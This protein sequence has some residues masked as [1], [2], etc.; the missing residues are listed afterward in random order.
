MDAIESVHETQSLNRNGTMLKDGNERNNSEHTKDGSTDCLGRPAARAKTGGWTSGMLLLVN[1]GLGA[2]AFVGVEVNLVLFSTRVLKQTNAEAANTFSRWMGTGMVLLTVSTHFS[3]LTPHGCGKVDFVCD[4]QSSLDMA[5]FY[6][7]IYLIA[8]GNGGYEPSLA[9]LGADQFDEEDETE[10]R[11]K[12]SFFSYFY[13]ALNLGSMFSETALAYFQN[14]GKWVMGFWISTGCGLIGLTVFLSGSL[15]Y[16]HFKPCGNPISRFSQVMCACFRKLKLEVPPDGEGLYE[17]QGNIGAASGARKINHTN[18]FRFLDRAAILSPKDTVVMTNSTNIFDPWSLCTVTQVEE[19][20]CVLRLIPIWI[21][22]I[23]YFLGFIQMISLFVEQGAAMHT[24]INSFHI[25]PA[26]MTVF[27]IVSISTFIVFY[28]Q[29]IRPYYRK[30]TRNNNPK[31]LSELQR[32]GIGLVFAIVAMIAAGVVEQQRRKYAIE[33][34]E[35]LSSLSIFWQVPQYIIL[36]VSEAF[37]Y[38]AQLEFFAAQIPDALKS[39]GVGLSMSSTAIGSYLTS[40][41]L[42]AVMEIT[43]K[44]GSPGWIPPNLNDGCMERFFFLLAGIM[45]INLLAFTYYAKRFKSTTFEKR[46]DHTKE[47]ETTLA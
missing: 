25:P 15:R 23:F 5:V 1:Q 12:A 37:M 3:L 45:A 41:L 36:G 7:S 34:G 43:T 16:R 20:K 11:S 32:M 14:L 39:L 17:V 10:K 6:M 38:V 9:T 47:A 42:S 26:S 27:D 2:L 22:S 31:G 33:G 44:N 18:D 13:V 35:E 40:M 24:R 30:V 29:I 28:D 4:S 21:C 19:V 8:L 46:E